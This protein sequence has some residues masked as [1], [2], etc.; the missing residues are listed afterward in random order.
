MRTMISRVVKI[1]K[2]T[3]SSS[4]SSNSGQ[5]LHYS[6]NIPAG[7][8]ISCRYKMQWYTSS[9][10]TTF[11]HASL[12][13]RSSSVMSRISHRRSLTHTHTCCNVILVSCMMILHV[14]S[15]AFVLFIGPLTELTAGTCDIRPPSSA[16][17]EYGTVQHTRGY[18]V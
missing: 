4:S 15:C 9:E 14:K 2:R 16:S 5:Q 8:F 6:R 3:S 13:S 11:C 17:V 1:A 10:D 12:F 7:Y 18:P